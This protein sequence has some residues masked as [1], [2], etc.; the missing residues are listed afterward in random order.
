[1]GPKCLTDYVFSCFLGGHFY[2]ENRVICPLATKSNLPSGK[3]VNKIRRSLSMA[4]QAMPFSSEVVQSLPTF[5]FP[6][7][8][9]VYHANKEPYMHYL[10]LTNIDGGRSYGCCLISYRSFSAVKVSQLTGNY[11]LLPPDEDPQTK[12]LYVPV[13]ICLVSKYPYFN[14]MKNMLSSLLPYLKTGESIWKPLLRFASHVSSIPVPPAGKLSI[15]VSLFDTHHVVPAAD[16]PDRRAIDLDWH[17][18]LLLLSVDDIVKVITSILTQQRIIF[19]SSSYQ[20]LTLVIESFFTFIDPFRWRLTY[21]PVLPNKLADLI[22]APGPF[23]MGCHSSIRNQV[24][25]VRKLPEIPAIIVVDLDKQ[26]VNEDPKCKLPVMPD[27]VSQALAVRLRKSKYQYDLELI[28]SPTFYSLEEAKRH[29]EQFLAE[30]Q[31]SI[32]TAC[33]DTMVSLFGDVLLH[34]RVGE[35][36]FDKDGYLQSILEDDHPFYRETCA[37]DCF[38]RFID[39]RLENPGK[40]DAFAVLAE[41]VVAARKTVNRNR[42]SSNVSQLRKHASLSAFAPFEDPKVVYQLPSL[43][44][45]GIHN[46]SYFQFCLKSLTESIEGLEGRNV[47]LKASYL[48][49]RGMMYVASK[50]PIKGLDDFH[51]LY[52]ANPELFPRELVSKVMMSLDDKMEGKL[53]EQ[54]FYK[55]TAAFQHFLRK[56]EEQRSRP[57]NRRLPSDPVGEAEF[58]KKMKTLQIAKSDEVAEWL[59]RMLTAE[60]GSDI[61]TPEQF[62]VLYDTLGEVER[63]M[64]TMDVPGAKIEDNE[65]V[66]MCSSLINTTKGV[67]RIMMTTNLLYFLSDGARVCELV[68]RLHDIK[69]IIKYQHYV[70]FPPGVAALRIVNKGKVCSNLNSVFVSMFD[71]GHCRVLI[72]TV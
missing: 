43:L 38:D 13:C 7:G 6:D 68:T 57:S 15:E 58:K 52:S 2:P 14:V 33:L 27:S 50:Q 23:I 49:L 46:G 22:E 36:F 51:S 71:R 8:G 32:K 40:R 44:D 35:K 34:M 31:R 24:R 30:F 39:E 19:L 1:M 66:L 59:F 5:C 65:Q 69:E 62:K 10:V 11:E 55:R 29:R 18:P 26:T 56:T 67:G 63:T 48:Y 12:I 53:K 54:D 64:D 3:A 61:V 17:L 37:S 45:E 72:N 28:K 60:E 25:Q 9:H 41:K 42:S 16:E 47:S 70:V 21:V 20:I 4:P